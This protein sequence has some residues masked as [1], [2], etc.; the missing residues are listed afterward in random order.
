MT[1]TNEKPATSTNAS[2]GRGEDPPAP[3]RRRRPRPPLTAAAAASYRGVLP[4]VHYRASVE[5][6]RPMS[7]FHRAQRL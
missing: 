1:P 7:E 4:T 3:R 2:R 5:E 6:E